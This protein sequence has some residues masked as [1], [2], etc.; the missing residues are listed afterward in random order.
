MIPK[1]HPTLTKTQTPNLLKKSQQPTATAHRYH[2]HQIR[3]QIAV[4]KTANKTTVTNKTPFPSK[5]RAT[6]SQ[7]TDQCYGGIKR[8]TPQYEKANTEGGS[9]GPDRKSTAVGRKVR[10][11]TP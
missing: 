9:G 7:Y 11:Q 10:N 8:K 1:S 3:R 6:T 5:K 2:Q 4:K